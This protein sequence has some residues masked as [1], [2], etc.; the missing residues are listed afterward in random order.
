MAFARSGAIRCYVSEEK[1][2][3]VTKTISAGVILLLI[4]ALIALVFL[5]NVLIKVAV[6]A[7]MVLV[8]IWIWNEIQKQTRRKKR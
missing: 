1:T 6:L 4:V 8:I 7:V 3:M 2:I 5:V